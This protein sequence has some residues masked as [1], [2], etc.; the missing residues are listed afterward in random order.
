[1]PFRQWMQRKLTPSSLLKSGHH[2][3]QCAILP[4]EGKRELEE[5]CKGFISHHLTC[6]LVG[7]SLWFESFNQV[8]KLSAAVVSEPVAG[9]GAEG[10]APIIGPPLPHQVQ[11][12]PHAQH[13]MTLFCRVPSRSDERMELWY[14]VQTDKATCWLS[15]EMKM[16]T[17]ACGNQFMCSE[18]YDRCVVPISKHSSTHVHTR[19]KAHLVSHPHAL[20][21]CFPLK[22]WSL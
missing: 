6:F 1:M 17:I 11:L 18:S 9:L 7:S 21:P 13:R 2:A 20:S 15:R 10:K 22:K 8:R 14:G 4:H 12:C 19:Y 5:V 16:E 3:R